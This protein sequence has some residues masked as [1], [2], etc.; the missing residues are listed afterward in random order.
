MYNNASNESAYQT[1]NMEYKVKPIRSTFFQSVSLSCIKRQV[2]INK[3]DCMSWTKQFTDSNIRFSGK[4][5]EI[6]RKRWANCF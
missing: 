3:V 2:R 4:F 6:R 5:I 1:S